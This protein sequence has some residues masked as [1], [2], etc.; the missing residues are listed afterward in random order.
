[1]WKVWIYPQVKLC[2]FTGYIHF[3][4]LWAMCAFKYFTK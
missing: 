1:M 2:I 3:M 4:Q